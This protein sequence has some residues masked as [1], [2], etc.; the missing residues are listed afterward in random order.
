MSRDHPVRGG[1]DLPPLP[2]SV[3]ITKCTKQIAAVSF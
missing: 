2:T 3:A 1:A